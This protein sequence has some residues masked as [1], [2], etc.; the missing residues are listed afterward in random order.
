MNHENA[1]KATKKNQLSYLFKLFRVNNEA[2]YYAINS[3]NHK[4]VGTI[5][6]HIGDVASSI[7]LKDTQIKE[8]KMVF[9]LKL[10]DNYPIVFQRK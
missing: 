5:H 1:S 8:A 9:L 6:H 2:Q 10:M 4:I 7:G 3:K